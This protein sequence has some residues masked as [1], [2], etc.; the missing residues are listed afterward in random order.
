MK[1]ESLHLRRELRLQGAGR[2]G[3]TGELLE[4]PL[5]SA[6]GDLSSC[7]IPAGVLAR[8]WGHINREF[9]FGQFCIRFA[10]QLL[11][12]RQSVVVRASIVALC[13]RSRMTCHQRA[14]RG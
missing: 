6:L 14:V 1:V 9:D 10:R 4:F 8:G 2:G 11:N 5:I 13:T 3:R 7:Y 12:F